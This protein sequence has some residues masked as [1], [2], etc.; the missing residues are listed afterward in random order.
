MG[1][2][3]WRPHF[4]QPAWSLGMSTCPI[5]QQVASALT[6]SEALLPA[7]VFPLAMSWEQVR[8]GHDRFSTT[9]GCE[10]S[11]SGSFMTRRRLPSGSVMAAR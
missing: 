11:F 6:D 8:D 4:G 7:V 9:Q 10:I 3:R 1:I 5:S 2:S